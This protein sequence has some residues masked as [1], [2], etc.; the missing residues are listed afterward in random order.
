[1]PRMRARNVSAPSFFQW[2][3]LG[4]RLGISS[5]ASNARNLRRGQQL[6]GFAS[7]EQFELGDGVL[8][9]LVSCFAT[10]KPDPNG[11]NES[12]PVEILSTE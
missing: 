9:D 6:N 10:I 4:F 5:P 11:T 8:H 7:E 3:D 1:M 2:Y 12:A